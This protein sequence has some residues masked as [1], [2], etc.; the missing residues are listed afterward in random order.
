MET[1]FLF[2]EQIA[3]SR[4]AHAPSCCEDFPDVAWGGGGGGLMASEI[5]KSFD[6]FVPQFNT[7]MSNGILCKYLRRK[8]F[9]FEWSKTVSNL[10]V[11]LIS[12]TEL[13]SAAFFYKS[14]TLLH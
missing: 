10:G 4:A 8:I 12:L 7:F 2:L 5:P 9:Q 6:V 14:S 11:R 1:I 13:C 3:L